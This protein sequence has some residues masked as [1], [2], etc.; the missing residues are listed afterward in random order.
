MLILLRPLE[1]FISIHLVREECVSVGDPP[2]HLLLI[3]SPNTFLKQIDIATLELIAMAKISSSIIKISF[4]KSLF[5][6]IY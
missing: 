5:S 6:L 3:N 1:L 4:M 2:V